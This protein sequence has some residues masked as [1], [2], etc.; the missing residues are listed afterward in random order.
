MSAEEDLSPEEKRRRRRYGVLGLR[1]DCL[2]F[3]ATP[4]NFLGVF[5]SCSFLITF[6]LAMN[7]IVLD[8]IERNFSLSSVKSSTLVAV[9][10]F[11]GVLS[12]IFISQLCDSHKVRWLSVG[13]VLFILGVIML[14]TCQKLVDIDTMFENNLNI[15]G[16]PSSLAT[17][18]RSTCSLQPN[19]S[20]GTIYWIL[21][22]SYTLQGI[23]ITPQGILGVTYIDELYHP[24]KVAFILAL[25]G[26]I[27][28]IGYPVS[29]LAGGWILRR[30]VT[31]KAPPM[32]LNPRSP[33]WIGAW[34]MGFLLGL[35]PLIIVTVPLVGFPRQMS[36]AVEVSRAKEEMG[37]RYSTSHSREESG[38]SV[39]R[40]I[41]TFLKRLFGNKSLVF[42]LLGDIVQFLQV[43]AFILF[44]PKFMAHAFN[45]DSTSVGLY[46][47]IIYGISFPLGSLVGGIFTR[48]FRMTGKEAALFM[49]L[50]TLVSTP[51]LLGNLFYCEQVQ[52]AG[53]THPY[54]GNGVVA[55]KF[56]EAHSTLHAGNSKLRSQCNE[57]CECTTLLYNPV[58]GTDNLT[59]FTPCFAGCQGRPTLDKKE[60]IYSNCT[61]VAGG[62]LNGG[63][64]RAGLCP[65]TDCHGRLIVYLICA[66][67]YML[68][69][70]V[71]YPP[72][73]LVYL[74]IV[75][76]QDRAAA[77]GLRTVTTK[78]F[79]QI[80]GPILLG[81]L[82]DNY[83]H[84]WKRNCEGD[85]NCW[86]YDM[87]GLTKILGSV[88]FIFIF[89]SSIFFLLCWYTFPER[90][91]SSERGR[92]SR[93][94]VNS[95]RPTT[96]DIEDTGSYL[97]TKQQ[98]FV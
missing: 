10:D 12:A 54:S 14:L 91:S 93:C 42:L 23:G 15:T 65:T 49:A 61:C 11:S 75:A 87:S 82:V 35:I 29:T 40:D 66:F 22:I 31:L 69:R 56:S 24:S 74:R 4:K 59:Y 78:L 26:G 38:S 84:V 70:F 52:F 33:A 53:V 45:L 68:L 85:S 92:D 41:K 20:L 83:C 57:R 64:A 62:D 96:V 43:A 8:S 34:W 81:Y 28:L 48:L 39:Y 77:Q 51:F 89:I 44:T 1:P 60:L 76:E 97:A 27:S 21:L 72:H 90:S 47:C 86:L 18:A 37:I 71:A 16:N 67:L 88:Y 73:Q 63:I 9:T 32:G 98:S 30:W 58:C 80:P 7:S 2:Q 17:C 95:V 50:T 6:T 46:I 79:G 94:G 19:N 13:N 25:Q 36:A 55:E 3:M 5:T